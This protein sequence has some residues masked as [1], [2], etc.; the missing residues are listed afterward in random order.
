MN[1]LAQKTEKL[2]KC[3]YLTIRIHLGSP[4]L[5]RKKKS[6]FERDILSTLNIKIREKKYHIV[7][8]ITTLIV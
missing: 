7:D 2:R 5:K 8:F 4:L 6:Y 3:N 1:G